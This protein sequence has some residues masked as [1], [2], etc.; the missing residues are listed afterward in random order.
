MI[1]FVGPK[2]VGMLAVPVAMP[3]GGSAWK[4]LLLASIAFGAAMILK[5][6][7]AAMRRG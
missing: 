7:S 2:L 1:G 5:S 3:E 4:Y 6:R